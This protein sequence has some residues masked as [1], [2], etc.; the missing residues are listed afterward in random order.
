VP[1]SG[2]GAKEIVKT[3]G[4]VG[5]P[6][7]KWAGGDSSIGRVPLPHAAIDMGKWER[8]HTGAWGQCENISLRRESG[9]HV[10]DLK[11]LKAATQSSVQMHWLL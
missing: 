11:N 3:W 2:L 9:V 4:G 6:E 8:A 5:S 7:N 10:S 1:R